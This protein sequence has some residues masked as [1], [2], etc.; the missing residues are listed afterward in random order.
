MSHFLN[1]RKA[2]AKKL[3]DQVPDYTKEDTI[4]AIEWAKDQLDKSI[5]PGYYI[6]ITAD[7]KFYLSTTQKATFADTGLVVCTFCKPE[8]SGD[9]SGT[10]M[11]TGA[12][13]IVMAVCEY[14]SG[15]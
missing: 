12:E 6:H 2:N 4:L 15:C 7:R 5:G 3:Y 10:P 9:H 13:A 11:E 8:W 1:L 14:L